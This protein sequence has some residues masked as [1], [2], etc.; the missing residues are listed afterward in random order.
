M[1]SAIELRW[2]NEKKKSVHSV[3]ASFLF[4]SL[5]ICSRAC[6]YAVRVWFQIC[7]RKETLDFF[8]LKEGFPHDELSLHSSCIQMSNFFF[9]PVSEFASMTGGM[10]ERHKEDRNNK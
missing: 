6:I 2:L 9:I 5:F 8:P 4:V 3:L 1:Q 10:S 7:L